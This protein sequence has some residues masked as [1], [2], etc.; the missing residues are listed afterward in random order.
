M[1]KVMRASEA[2]TPDIKYGV[3]S[4]RKPFDWKKAI[5]YTLL[6]VLAAV[7]LFPLIWLFD[8]SLVK[9]GEVF[10]ADFLKWPNP[11]Q[12]IN[13]LRAWTNGMILPY[14][15]NSVI[16]VTLTVILGVICS[17]MVAYA[18]T[19]MTWK[20]RSLV[21]GFIMLGM[22]VPIHAT[23]LP[24]FLL[25]NKLNMLD[26][27]WALIIPYTA[28]SL[29]FNTLIF[30]GFLKS[31]PRALEESAIIDGCGT[32]GV[33]F[34]IVAPISKPAMMTVAVMTFVGNWNEFI[35][36]NTFLSTDTYRTLPFSVIK[37]MGYYVSDYATQFACMMLV[38]LPTLL[39]YVFLNKYITE[40]ATVGAVKG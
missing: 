24:N 30:T 26:S 36:A 11:P 5:V 3:Q 14:F 28:F 2:G 37:F 17:F 19:R 35:M 27:Y 31:V 40:G 4:Y 1:Q 38:A 20:G 9:S 23:L 29:S 10:G 39:V 7:Q 15:I 34:R 21:Y 16:V 13:Y 6:S 12:W 25:F 22:M 18:C 8:F 33:M 32:W